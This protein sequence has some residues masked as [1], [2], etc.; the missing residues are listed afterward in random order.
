MITSVDSYYP[1]VSTGKLVGSVAALPPKKP[2]SIVIMR[3][4]LTNQ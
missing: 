2:V 4:R 3:N 1:C